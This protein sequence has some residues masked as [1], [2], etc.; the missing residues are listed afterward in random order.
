[1][2]IERLRQTYDVEICFV[3]FPLHPETPAEGQTLAQLFAGRPIDLPAAQAHMKKLMAA[4]GLPYGN[5]TMTYNSLLAQ[6][7]ATWAVGRG[8]A[9]D[10]F[11]SRRFVP[12][13][14]R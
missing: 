12:S 11:H 4:E 5:R 13:L 3:H 1:M 7:M 14:L 9:G 8:S 2:C 10:R 6:E